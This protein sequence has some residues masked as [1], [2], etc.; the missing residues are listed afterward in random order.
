[1]R[2]S[3]DLL[4][5]AP[6]QLGL[7][8]SLDAWPRGAAVLAPA[9][10]LADF[11]VTTPASA[12][13]YF[14]AFAAAA[15]CALSP[16]LPFARALPPHL[17]CWREAEGTTEGGG[18]VGGGAGGEAGVGGSGVGGWDVGA[19]IVGAS[20]ALHAI[21]LSPA[22]QHPA[23]RARA[24]AVNAT[25]PRLDAAPG[26]PFRSREGLREVCITYRDVL[27]R[28]NLSAAELAAYTRRNSTGGGASSLLLPLAAAAVLATALC[29]PLRA[30]ARSSGGA[31]L[32]ATRRVTAPLRAAAAPLIDP[33]ID[34]LLPMARAAA[35]AVAPM[36]A[37]LG[38]TVAP[39]ADAAAR[40]VGALDASVRPHAPHQIS[41]A[42]DLTRPPLPRPPQTSPSPRAPQT[43]S[44]GPRRTPTHHLTRALKPSHVT[45]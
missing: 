37:T 35:D 40:A 23:H 27:K 28:P 45:G 19:C 11:A 38:E 1:M 7:N 8:A 10:A 13:G 4:F 30:R 43:Y 6:L 34:P 24:C 31:L 21:R 44:S 36:L 15:G 16:S 18:G 2:I 12:P 42:P 39:A 22:A 9:G 20:L 26:G 3:P 33:L 14:G 41:P 5:F 32:S 25:S 17:R 29:V